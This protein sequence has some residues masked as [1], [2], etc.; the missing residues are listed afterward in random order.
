MKN[1]NTSEEKFDIIME[2][3]NTNITVVD[4]CRKYGMVSSAYYRWKEQ[5]FAGAK[6]L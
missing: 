3:I 2:S 6:A 1:Y 5:F 4:L